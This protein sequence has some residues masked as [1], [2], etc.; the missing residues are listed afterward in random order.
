MSKYGMEVGGKTVYGIASPDKA[1]ELIELVVAQYY[2][3]FWTQHKP[4][5]P[6]CDMGL[7]DTEKHMNR[8]VGEC[9]NLKCGST[10]HI[11]DFMGK[12]K[13]VLSEWALAKDDWKEEIQK[14]LEKKVRAKKHYQGQG[15]GAGTTASAN[16]GTHDTEVI[17]EETVFVW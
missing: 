9:T 13:D 1:L 5:C 8:P 12:L 17:D 16:Y 2:G 3:E 7:K 4:R 15:Q 11:S 6:L 10:I 14:E